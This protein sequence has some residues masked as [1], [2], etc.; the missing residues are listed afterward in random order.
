MILPA[1]A[2]NSLLDLHNSDH[3]KTSSNNLF[4]IH[5]KYYMPSL[6][7]KQKQSCLPRS[8]SVVVF[9]FSA[10]QG[11]KTM[12]S[13]PVIF[14]IAIVFR[15]VL[16]FSTFAIFLGSNS[17]F[18]FLIRKTCEISAILKNTSHRLQGSLLSLFAIPF[19][20]FSSVINLSFFYRMP[21]T[22]SKFGQRLL[23]LKN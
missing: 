14:Q 22:S 11:Y 4:I 2:D 16:F 19:S 10:I 9:I 18:H 5:L 12:F 6:N 15:R 20:V 3:A 21:L 1:E 23:V 13:P 7:C 17:T 8:T